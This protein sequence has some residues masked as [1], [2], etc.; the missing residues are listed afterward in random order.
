VTNSAERSR[1][2]AAQRTQPWVVRGDQ[3]SACA[4]QLPIAE[5]TA[6]CRHAHIIKA[7]ARLV[8]QENV[9]RCG[10]GHDDR[11]STPLAVGESPRRRVEKASD[12]EA[13]G[14]DFGTG[15]ITYGN[16]RTRRSCAEEE[17][18]ILR[19]ESDLQFRCGDSFAP[20]N[21]QRP[22]YKM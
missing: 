9:W 12:V 1:I 15:G 13:L 7:A 2:W 6:E 22:R 17:A 14:K 21:W 16:Q 3:Y 5:E 20:I 10:K 11:E 8:E 4:E 19:R 18:R